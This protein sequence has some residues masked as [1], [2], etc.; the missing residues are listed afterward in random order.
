MKTPVALLLATLLAFS[1]GCRSVPHPATAGT[2]PQDASAATPSAEDEA[3]R[4]VRLL[5]KTMLLVRHN[6]VD[7][8]KVS[9]SNL[10][11]AAL[12]GMLQSLDPF[13]QYLEPVAYKELREETR[14]RFGGV[15]IQLGFK[16]NMLTVIA[17]MEDTPAFRAGILSGDKIVEINT[18]KTEK[19]DLREVITRLRGEPGTPVSIKILRSGEFK[20]HT[21]VREEIKVSSIKGT[22]MLDPAIGYIRI[23]EF[24]EPTAPA[25]QEA[26]ESLLARD[27]KALVLDLRNNPGGLLTSSILVS[28][29]FLPKDAVVVSTRGRG[30]SP[31]ETTSTARGDHHYTDLPLAVLI[32]GGSASAAEI[33]AGALHDNKR[34]ILVG[35]TTFGKGSVQNIMPV[36]EG[37]A[38]RITTA[39]YYTPSGKCIHEKGIE[40]D[41]AVPVPPEEW[42]KV[43]LK[44]IETETPSAVDP[45]TRPA[46]LDKVTDRQLDRAVDLLKGIMIFQGRSTEG[47]R[48]Q[49]SGKP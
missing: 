28:E 18:N 15:G 8:N 36:E 45:K 20:T 9:Y 16:D 37:T 42:Q 47:F 46:D 21:L 13:S 34:A 40:P 35:E 44:R 2:P 33:V 29:K 48:G 39:H 38:A 7:E 10:V 41:I 1:A 26:L 24:S 6:Y 12:K 43:L 14:G 17:P 27:M 31:R 4:Q 22:R 32:N 23:T 19:M 5:T 25:L 49:G 30:A 3:Y 11:S